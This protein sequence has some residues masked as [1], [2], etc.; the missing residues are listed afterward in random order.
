MIKQI[1]EENQTLKEKIA[2][3]EIQANS[4]QSSDQRKSEDI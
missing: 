2:Q 3:F 1:K 4:Q